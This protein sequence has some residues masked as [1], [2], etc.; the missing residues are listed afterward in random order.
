VIGNS[1]KESAV[2][3]TCSMHMKIRNA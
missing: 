3:M 2:A 1:L